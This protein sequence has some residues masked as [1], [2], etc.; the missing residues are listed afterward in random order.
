MINSFYLLLHKSFRE[1]TITIFDY[2]FLKKTK[3]MQL[4]ILQKLNQIAQ[5][6]M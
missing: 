2:Y 4:K 1:F 5:E 6:K 3:K